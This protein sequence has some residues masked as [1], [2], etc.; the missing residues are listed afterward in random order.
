MLNG[1]QSP[2]D[3]CEREVWND[4]RKIDLDGFFT[5]ADLDTIDFPELQ[6]VVPGI[7]P[8]GLAILAGKPKFGKSYLC[9]GLAVAAATGGKALHAID[10]E[11][12]DVL[13]LA[14]EDGPRRLKDRMR[15]MLPYS[16]KP[17]R[18][19]FCTK[20]KRVGDGLEEMIEKWIGSVPNPRLVII[21]TWRTVKLASNGRGSAY[22]ED[23]TGLNPLHQLTKD[24]P[25]LAMLVVH[26][27]RKLDA[28]DPFDTISGTHGLTG[29]ADTL[30][31]AGNHGEGAK[32]SGQGRD[33][34][35]YE[36]ALVRDKL[37]GGW[38]L[39]GDARELAKT[40]ERQEI[41]NVLNEAEGEPVSL[42][43]VALEVGK[44][45]S[46]VFHLLKRMIGE[47]LVRKQGHGKYVSIPHSTHSTH[48]TWHDTDRDDDAEL[49]ELNELN[50]GTE[51]D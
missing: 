11:A 47:G 13:Y 23:A 1:A 37:T 35:G 32:L 18:I 40:S 43:A 9:M 6:Y 16:D 41:L 29:V 42:A 10:C 26:H 51:D 44:T 8:E 49:N 4:P 36:K 15:Q 17:H 21:D 38:K 7:L 46:N 34:E 25:G 50:G 5:A 28:D 30:M 33:I 31:V 14:F 39:N 3:Q 20:A 48:S 2:F 45:K 12:G 27:T 24:H 22:D 19:T